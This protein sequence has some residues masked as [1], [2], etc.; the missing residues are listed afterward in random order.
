MLFRTSWLSFEVPLLRRRL[1]AYVFR[2]GIR[3]IKE[4]DYKLVKLNS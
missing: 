3:R 4:G 2:G 1:P